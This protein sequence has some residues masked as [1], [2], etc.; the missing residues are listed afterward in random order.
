MTELE[1]EILSEIELN[2]P[3]L[4]CR[5]TGDFFFLEKHGEEKLKNFIKHFNEKHQILRSTGEWSQASINV[6]DATISLVWMEMLLQIVIN[7]FT[8]LHVNH[9]TAKSEFHTVKLFILIETV[10]I[11]IL[12]IQDVMILKSG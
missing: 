7:I 2:T 12:L 6:L 8:L 3:Y 10:Q 9:I 11:L 4:W 1:E 5:Y